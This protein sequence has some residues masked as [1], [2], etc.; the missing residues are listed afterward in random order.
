MSSNIKSCVIRVIVVSGLLEHSVCCQCDCK[1]SVIFFGIE[2]QSATKANLFAVSCQGCFLEVD[3]CKHSFRDEDESDHEKD[4]RE[5]GTNQRAMCR[6]AILQ[7]E[8]E[9]P[10]VH[11]NGETGLPDSDVAV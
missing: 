11:V 5:E 3:E 6:V 9:W 10:T 2:S 7:A 4:Q 8:V 1:F